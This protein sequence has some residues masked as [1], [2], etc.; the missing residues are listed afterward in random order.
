MSVED[1]QRAAAEPVEIMTR[2]KTSMMWEQK[3]RRTRRKALETARSPAEW[4]K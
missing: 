1:A 4:Y 3:E 2:D